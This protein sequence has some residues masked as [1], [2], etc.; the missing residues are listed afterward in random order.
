MKRVT[1]IVMGAA[2]AFLAVVAQ[3]FLW[4][5]P[6]PAYGLCVVC[7][8]RDLVIWLLAALTGAKLDVAAVSAQWPL[9]TVAGILLGSRYAAA[10]SQECQSGWVEQ[11]LTAFGCGM[12]VMILGLI[13]MACPTR[14]LLR[15]A[16]G[17]FSGAAGAAA[18]LVGAA[19]ATLYMRWR[20]KQCSPH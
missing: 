6:P 10:T 2:T 1:P 7:H 14:L 13:I 20:A 5:Q 18:V 3:A 9:L 8:G 15:A 12:M 11:P 4:V 17:D 19:A 16:Y